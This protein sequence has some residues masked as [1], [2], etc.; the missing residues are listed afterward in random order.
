MATQGIVSILS[1]GRMLFKVVA[2]S[3]GYNASKL[4]DWAKAHEGVMT[5]E[6]VYQAAIKCQ[7]GGKSDMVVQA[8]DGSLTC[9]G[10]ENC[11]EDFGELYRDNS[12][13]LDPRFNPRWAQGIAD[14]VAVVEVDQA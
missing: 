8:S 2:G 7:F 3:D 12:K 4:A 13:F 9:D 14:Y 6:D 10:D 11:S 1:G 5:N